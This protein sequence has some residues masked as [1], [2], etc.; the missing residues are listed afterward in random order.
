MSY[1]IDWRQGIF[2]ALGMAWLAALSNPAQDNLIDYRCTAT[3]GLP[4]PLSLALSF[5]LSESLMRCVCAQ[6]GCTRPQAFLVCT[7]R[8]KVQQ[9]V[10]CCIHTWG[11]SACCPTARSQLPGRSAFFS[12]LLLY[13]IPPYLLRFISSANAM[14]LHA[15]RSPET[16]ACTSTETLPAAGIRLLYCCQQQ[17]AMIARSAVTAISMDPSIDLVP[18]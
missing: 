9:R 7:Q 1:W 18:A 13:S 11:C 4:D 12:T 16:A 15:S 3:R 10:A 6:V 14:T 8:A 17:E 2:Q 5:T